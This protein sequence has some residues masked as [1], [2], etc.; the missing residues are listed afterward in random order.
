M[1]AA[2]LGLEIISTLT[3]P[4]GFVASP[5]RPALRER[6]NLWL[7]LTALGRI[8]DAKSSRLENDSVSIIFNVHK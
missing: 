1:S 4:S 2:P 3:H 5:L 6:A 7:R 8:Q